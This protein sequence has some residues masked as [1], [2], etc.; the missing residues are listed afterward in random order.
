MRLPLLRYP[1]KELCKSETRA[2]AVMG[3]PYTIS[4][5]LFL[6]RENACQ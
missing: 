4:R 2:A 1:Q 6:N 3:P 5:W